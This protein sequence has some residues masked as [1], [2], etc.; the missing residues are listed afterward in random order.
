VRHSGNE[1]YFENLI[2]ALLHAADPT[3]QYFVFSYRAAAAAL[4][5]G[6]HAVHVPLRSRSVWWQRGVEIPQLSRRLDLDVLHVPFNFL[7]V[8]RCRKI[9]T[10]HDLGFLRMPHLY[11]PLE[12]YR[13]RVLTRL[14]ARR[15]DHILTG[16]ALVKREIVEDYGVAPD[17]V[18]VAP[19]G[20][21]SAVFR[22]LATEQRHVA[23]QRLGLPDAY[24]LFVGVIQARKNLRVLL[25]ALEILRDRGRTDVHLVLAGRLGYGAEDVFRCVQQRGLAPVVRHLGVVPTDALVGLYNNALALVFPSLLE[26]FGIP[27]LEAMASGCPV[28][29][30]NAAALPEVYGDAALSFDP[31]DPEELVLRLS[32]LLEDGALA[33]RLRA[34]GHRRAERFSWER[35]ASAVRAVYAAS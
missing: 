22:P 23:R 11:A 5:P 19:Y 31:H 15:A 34:D 13:M 32:Q 3:Q 7:P 21:D 17:R 4:L 30:S 2:R 6:D 16:S 24:L 8:G 18:T 12:R 14:A 10:I 25:R 20:V 35:A 26:G 29:S 9:V 27:I 1:Q 28:V 33:Q